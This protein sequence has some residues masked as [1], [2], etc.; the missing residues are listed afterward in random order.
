[1][2]KSAIIFCTLSSLNAT[3]IT[4]ENSDNVISECENLIECNK[5]TI[6]EN[7]LRTLLFSSD[8]N[9]ESKIL[10]WN[11]VELFEV[12]EEVELN[13]DT[14]TYL[15]E[16][17]NP[18][19]GKNNLDWNTIK[20]VEVEEEV[21]LG[22]DTKDYLPVNFNALKGGK[23]DLDW[24]SIELIELEEEVDLGFDTKNYLPFGFDAKSG[25]YKNKLM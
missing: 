16:N 8:F 6:E 7:N 18:L 13:F 11:A 25:M 17:F 3:I 19:K 21:D 4:N 15:P 20:L 12:E 1:M 10:D 5:L 23:H 9:E 14:K 24:N 2:I 22:F